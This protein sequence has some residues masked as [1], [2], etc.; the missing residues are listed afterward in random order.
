MRA[1]VYALSI[2]LQLFVLCIGLYHCVVGV[3][4]FIDRKKKENISDQKNVF[5]LVVAAHNERSVIQQMVQSLKGID[6]DKDKYDIFV[7]ADNCTDDTATLAANAGAL[8]HE[9][10]HSEKRG[11]GYALEWMFDRIFNMEKQ[12]D[13]ICIFDADNIVD[14]QYLNEIN[15]KLNEGYKAV[16]GYVDT[17]NPNDSWITASYAISFW[18]L[19]KVFQTARSNAGLS[20]QINGT[21][22]ALR[23]EIIKEMGWGATC[24]TE[25]MEFTMK[26]ILN[27]IKVGW[28]KKAVIY[29]EK[30]LTL[31]QSFKQRTRW[32]QGHTDVASRFIKPLAKKWL[33]E[34]D[35]S[36]F[37]GMIYLFQPMLLVAM[38]ISTVMSI[39]QLFYPTVDFWFTP[40]MLDLSPMAWNLIMLVQLA[41]FPFVLWLEKKLTWKMI[42]YY[43][44]YIAFTYT[45]MPIAAVGMAKK[46]QKEWFHTQHTRK[47][48]IE[49]IES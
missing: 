8:V 23:T 9:R 7:V 2:L 44:P 31:S 43:I 12:Y 21:G 10:F 25:D 19:N 36:A 33:K 20:N 27:N 3:F 40:N 48:S 42:F 13:A 5:A 4:A 30:P 29:D 26:L 1:V 17:K 16:Q 6:Y 32:M 15:K 35:W 49:E 45:W 28:A 18:C 47:I 39:A 11:K 24:L 14:A 34:N 37:D 38:L 41:F 22:F 46:N